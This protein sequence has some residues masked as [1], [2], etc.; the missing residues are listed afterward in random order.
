MG[1]GLGTLF[2]EAWKNTLET[3]IYA[4]SSAENPI[5]RSIVIDPAVGSV[6]F[7]GITVWGLPSQ[8]YVFI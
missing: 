3:T 8:L 6:C 4:E 7:Q 2:R 5:A 1:I